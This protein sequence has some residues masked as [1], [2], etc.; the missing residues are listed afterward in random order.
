MTIFVGFCFL[1]TKRLYFFL[2]SS[3]KLNVKG[4]NLL[5]THEHEKYWEWVLS[6]MTRR[7]ITSTISLI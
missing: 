1:L 3:C 7:S 4:C 6:D 2:M 5:T